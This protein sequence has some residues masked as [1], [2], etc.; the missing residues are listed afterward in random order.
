MNNT[1]LRSTRAALLL[2]LAVG[3]AAASANTRQD[4]K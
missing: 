1:C 2:A 4:A 3:L